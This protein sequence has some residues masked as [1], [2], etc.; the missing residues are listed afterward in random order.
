MSTTNN[1]DCASPASQPAAHC[2][3]HAMVAPKDH[4]ADEEGLQL[5]GGRRPSTVSYT[6]LRAHETSAHL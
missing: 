6:H 5:D 2:N 1:C 3:D 4:H